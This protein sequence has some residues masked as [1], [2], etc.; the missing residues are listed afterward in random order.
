MENKVNLISDREMKIE[1]VLNV[2]I[3]LV[4]KTFTDT[5]QLANAF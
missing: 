2:P 4:W 3:A 1:F 5:D